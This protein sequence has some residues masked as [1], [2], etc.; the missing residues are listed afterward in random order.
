VARL[1]EV[2]AGMLRDLVESR[3][4]ADALSRE[5][6]DQ[7][8]ADPILSQ[9]PVPRFAVREVSLKLRFAV[10]EIHAAK[11]SAD[12]V[13]LV[14]NAW[15]REV[16]ERVVPASLG[17]LA[18]EPTAAAALVARLRGTPTPALDVTGLTR[19]SP[20]RLAAATAQWVLAGRTGLADAIRRKLPGAATLR[21]TMTTALTA[22]LETFG[23]RARQLFGE[24]AALRSELEIAVKRTELD[25]IPESRIH[26][27]TLVLTTDDLQ[28]AGPADA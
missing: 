13:A 4:A 26:E 20:G 27:L 7:Y 15:V 11:P 17:A 23:P 9:V 1:N 12:D 21:S 8:R 28:L 10:E 25:Q 3:V 24:G 14:R 19:G 5:H 22:A 16:I 6:A 18:V 2:V